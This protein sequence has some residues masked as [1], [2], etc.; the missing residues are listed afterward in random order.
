M[1]SLGKESLIATGKQKGHVVHG[2]S[3]A[4]EAAA[5]G[6][7]AENATALEEVWTPPIHKCVAVSA[8]GIDELVAS[9][10]LHHRW[11]LETEAGRLRRRRR[12]GEEVRESLRE[13]LIEAATNS[14]HAELDAAVSAVEAKQV[15]PYGAIEDLVKKFLSR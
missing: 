8:K 15:D 5:H 10:A 12:L 11:T 6:V 4:A 7:G 14:L 2:A 3:A 9:I 13:A 1:I